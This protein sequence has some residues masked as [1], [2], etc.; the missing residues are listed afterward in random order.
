MIQLEIVPAPESLL[1][2]SPISCKVS[3][4]ASLALSATPSNSTTV[5]L[6]VKGSIKVS[7]LDLDI[8]VSY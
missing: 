7:N 2:E 8:S 5:C 3:P 1:L 4:A 6:K